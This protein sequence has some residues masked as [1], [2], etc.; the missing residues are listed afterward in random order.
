MA[1]ERLTKRWGNV[2]PSTMQAVEQRVRHLL[3]L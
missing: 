3:E 2:S 1:E